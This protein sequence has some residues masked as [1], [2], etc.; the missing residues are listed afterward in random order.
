M[1][2][3]KSDRQYAEEAERLIR[4]AMRLFPDLPPVDALIAEAAYGNTIKGSTIRRLRPSYRLAFLKLAP[5]AGARYGQLLDNLE[6]RRGTPDPKRGASRKV[7]KVDKK[8]V[9]DTFERLRSITLRT[10]SR[11]AFAAALYTLVVPRVAIRPIE[12]LDAEVIGTDLLVHNAK[13][14]PGLPTFRRV[15]LAR[16]PPTLI[17]AAKW[18]CALARQGVGEGPEETR[19]A[20]FNAWRNRVAESLA[21]ASKP[22]M[23]EDQRLS[24]YSFRHIGIATWKAAGFSKE[25]IALLAGHLG[26]HTADKH[27]APARSGWADEARLAQPVRTA[28]ADRNAVKTPASSTRTERDAAEANSPEP[29]PDVPVSAEA[30]SS[31]KT[32]LIDVDDFPVPPPRKERRS[33]TVAFGPYR[34]ALEKMAERAAGSARR[35]GSGYSAPARPVVPGIGEDE[36]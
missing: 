4:R 8:I 25:E 28:E 23:P 7:K 17:E 16:F 5:A 36:G 19:E 6:G 12:L 31:P 2:K 24:L 33:D 18:L 11:S 35:L 1:A 10:R 30:P 3:K 20:R 29:T 21:R 34:Q 15:S 9:I 13:W 27:Y 32:P 26:L 22:Y 14:R